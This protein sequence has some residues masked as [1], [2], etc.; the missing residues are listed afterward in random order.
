MHWFTDVITKRY[1]QFSGRARRKEFWMF[2]LFSVVISIILSILDR[3]LG[4]DWKQSNGVSSGG[5]LQTIYGL[6][7]LV[8]TIAIAVRRFHDRDKSGWW[9]L[10]WLIPCVGWIWFIVWARHGG[11][12]RRQP[13][14]SGPEG[15]RARPGLRWTDRA[16]RAG[17][18][19]GLTS[20]ERPANLF[21]V[22]G[23]FS[24]L[25]WPG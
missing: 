1:A 9:V 7:V 17:V 20:A 14:R 21:E 2:T 11:H 13:V 22:R 16:A 24:L 3:I 18:P 8:P 19:D 15:G 6:A 10:I 5:W 25:S 23:A 12:A 4:L